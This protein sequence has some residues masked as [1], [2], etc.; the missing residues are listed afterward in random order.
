MRDRTFPLH[1]FSGSHR[2]IGRAFGQACAADIH[3]HRDLALDRLDQRSGIAPDRA[4]AAA[5]AYRPFVVEHAPFLDEEIQGVGEGAGLSLAEAYLLQ[6]RAELAV[7]TPKGDA[8]E[9]GDECTTFAVLPEATADGAPL[10]GQNADLPAFYTEIS[11]VVE[12]VPDD[13]P[14]VLM[15]TPAG[16][17][18][19]IGIN[20]RGLSVFANYLTCD[21]WRVGFPRYLLSRLALTKA[22]VNEAIAA[23]RAVPRA[24]SRN[25]IMLDATGVAAD[26]E[27]TP[28][29]DA[30]LDPV[31]G[32]LAHSNHYVAPALLAEERSPERWVANSRVRLDRMDALLARERGRLDTETMQAILRD[33]VC[34]PDAL[35]RMPGDD[36]E[37]DVITFAS[38]VAE[39]TQ[40]RLSVAVG[41]PNEHPY[42]SYEFARTPNLEPAPETA[43]S[44]S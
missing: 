18:S 21:G 32:L 36:E 4:L 39:P 24:S 13:A 20:D 28:T 15:L 22:T 19:Y 2:A 42:R 12:F 31:A 23:V 5:L 40:G 33:R 3:R 6:L 37:G 35:C 17:V 38:V 26:L 8:A 14:A 41:P 25:L 29:R 1:R 34:H 16:Q 10:V 43:T 11:V 30:R 27:T 44:R 7:V 9:H